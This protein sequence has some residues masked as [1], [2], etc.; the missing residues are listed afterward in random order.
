MQ[1]LH[2]HTTLSDGIDTP[3]A[4]INHAIMQGFRSIGISDHAKTDFLL[5]YEANTEKYIDEISRLREKYA[6][7]IKIFLGIEMDFY[8]KGHLNPR[9]FDYVIGSVHY[10]KTKDGKMIAYDHSPEIA[11]EHIQND[12]GGDAYAYA[13]SY[14]E[15]V[16]T[17][18]D[19]FDF[20]IVGHF[21]V[22]TKY[23]E[24][25]SCFFDTGSHA[26]RNM[27]LEALHSIREKRELFEINT[28]AI[29][30]GWRTSPYPESF[31]LH[32]MKRLSCKMILSSDCHNGKFLNCY[33][34]E[35]LDI[36]RAHGFSE[37]YYLTKHGFKGEK[38]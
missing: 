29:A 35:A 13:R 27:A 21:D 17:L 14:F 31:I 15:N 33:F 36:L 25:Y 1:N 24:K 10:A 26:Y 9:D 3:E 4:M 19:R 18:G 20:N 7:K 22:L 32:E 30:R 28:G 34:K 37:I 6:E 5:S 11:I 12:F 2:T 16:A 8:S 38:I 23:T